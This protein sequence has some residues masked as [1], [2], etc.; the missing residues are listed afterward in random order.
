MTHEEL[1]QMGWHRKDIEPGL[2]P[3]VFLYSWSLIP[4]AISILMITF[5][6]YPEYLFYA[7]LSAISLQSVSLYLTLSKRKISLYYD[8]VRNR[9]FIVSLILVVFMLVRFTNS[10]FSSLIQV[11][12]TI[13]CS[14]SILK[15]LQI[16]TNNIGSTYQHSWNGEDKLSKQELSN[17]NVHSYLFGQKLLAERKVSEIGG[18]AWISGAVDDQN[19]KLTVDVFGHKSKDEFDFSS[20]QIELDI[21]E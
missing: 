4:I 18:I 14:Y 7:C 15:T 9:L 6:K 20:L 5:D 1:A 19:P 13:L 12:L 3:I 10:E 21:I 17:W 2:G 11:I 8:P 16:F